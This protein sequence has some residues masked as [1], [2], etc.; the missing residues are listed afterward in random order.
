VVGLKGALV[1]LAVFFLIGYL[2]TTN[3]AIPP[4]MT[5]YGLLNVPVLDYPVL[6]M[7][8]TTLAVS[9]LNGVVYGIVVYV[10]FS[11]LT[12]RGRKEPEKDR[13][14]VKNVFEEPT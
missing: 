12:L 6:G 4:G 10:A 13:V 1:F 5:L 7:P 14:F 9:V 3:T 2:T 8:V 11:L